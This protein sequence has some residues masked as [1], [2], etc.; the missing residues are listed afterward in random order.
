MIAN[1]I[2]DNV[3]QFRDVVIRS[4]KVDDNSI[5]ADDCFIANSSIG[6]NCLIERRNMILNSDIGDNSFTGYNTV[7]KYATIGKYC[8]ISWNVSVGGGNHDY[9]CLTTH[10][11]PF[12][13]RYE[14]SPETQNYQSFAEPLTIGNDVWIGSNVCILRNVKIGDG[15]VVGA[16]S[17]VTKD[18][19][20]YA[21]AIGV[22]AK[23]YKYRF[24]QT[25]I[26]KLLKLKWWEWSSDALKAN[27]ALFQGELD[28][29]KLSIIEKLIATDLPDS[30]DN[31]PAK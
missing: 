9:Q 10:P 30:V 18:I 16:G 4:S 24:E 21:I 29:N 11:F 22:P 26:S 20:P 17:V 12:D 19:P 31:T 1:V 2:G 23:I 7:I 15:A 14:I 13:Q 27:L 6:R 28:N 5:I 25:I 8:S 3:R